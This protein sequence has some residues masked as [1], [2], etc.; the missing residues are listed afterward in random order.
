MT[1]LLVIHV[2][3]L[4]HN[5]QTN[6]V[7]KTWDRFLRPM[8]LP[9]DIILQARHCLSLQ[10]STHAHLVADAASLA[11]RPLV[12]ALINHWQLC[13][14]DHYP[15]LELHSIPHWPPTGDVENHG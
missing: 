14:M 12:Y 5:I 6:G 4:F 7:N 11:F 9:C 13:L 2:T 1:G 15:Q 3:T 10:A 8:G